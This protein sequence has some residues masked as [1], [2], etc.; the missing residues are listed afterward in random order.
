VDINFA[1]ASMA[2]KTRNAITTRLT[3]EVWLE[4]LKLL[5]YDIRRI[6]TII[7]ELNK[8]P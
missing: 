2:G 3:A 7:L 4:N 1:M 8:V 5:K 6:L